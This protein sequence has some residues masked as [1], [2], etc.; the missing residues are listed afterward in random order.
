M[1]TAATTTS[2]IL[3]TQPGCL[4][5][6]LMRVFLEAHQ[7]AFEERNIG[8]DLDARRAMREQYNSEETPMLLVVSRGV[9]GGVSG[10]VKEVIVGFDPVRLDQLLDPPPSSD[11]VTES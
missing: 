8:E 7:V 1:R 6:D 10:E 4:S 5:C 9:S 3:F 11:S 2:F